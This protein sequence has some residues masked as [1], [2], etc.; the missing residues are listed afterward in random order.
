MRILAVDYG[1]RRTGLAVSDELGITA[2]G[3]DT[4]TVRDEGE[5]LE[6][7]A[8]AVAEYRAETVVVG[9]PLNMNG[10]ESEKSLKVRVFADAL[11]QRTGAAV[12]FRDERMTSLQA[13]RVMHETGR[14]T[15]GNKGIVDRISATILLQEHLKT[16]P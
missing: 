15:K 8:A 11:A 12:V 6:R 2:Q 14:K 3:L 7:V 9:L 1:E 16:L 13:T 5:I 4:V 10:T